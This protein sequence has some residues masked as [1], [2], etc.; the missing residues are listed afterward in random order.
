MAEIKTCPRCA[1]QRGTE[2]TE[3]TVET[4]SQGNMVPK[5]R[6]VWNAC[7]YC[8]GNGTVVE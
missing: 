4:D 5:Q 2:K 8:G 7:S 1:G 3:H 6:T